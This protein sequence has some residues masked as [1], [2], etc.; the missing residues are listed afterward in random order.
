MGL[1]EV[2]LENCLGIDQMEAWSDFI[3]LPNEGNIGKFGKD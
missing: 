1:K 2:E 3:K